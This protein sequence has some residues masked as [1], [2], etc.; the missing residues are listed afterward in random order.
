MTQLCVVCWAWTATA[1]SFK[2]SISNLTLCSIFSFEIFWKRGRKYMTLEYCEI[3][4]SNISSFFNQPLS[5]FLKLPIIRHLTTVRTTEAAGVKS[6]SFEYIACP[7]Y[8]WSTCSL[9]K[10]FKRWTW[11]PWIRNRLQQ[12]LYFAREHNCHGILYFLNSIAKT[13]KIIKNNNEEKTKWT[14]KQKCV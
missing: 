14:I 9:K 4:R 12:Q 7:W 6:R 3:R 5:S 1:I 13:K 10:K 8:N 11:A 2:T